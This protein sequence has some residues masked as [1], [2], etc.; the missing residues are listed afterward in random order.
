MKA[1]PFSTTPWQSLA[2]DKGGSFCKV[3]MHPVTALPD[4]EFARRG[5]GHPRKR[6][7]RWKGCQANRQTQHYG[8][9]NALMV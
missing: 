4:Y 7:R 3:Q 8:L 9:Q 5:D 6:C 2:R 1:N